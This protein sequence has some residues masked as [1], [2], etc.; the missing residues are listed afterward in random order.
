MF[1]QFVGLA[2]KGVTWRETLSL[3]LARSKGFP[4]F[5]GQPFHKTIYYHYHHYILNPLMY[6]VPEWSDTF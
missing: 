1:E 4:P 6:N 2:L 5:V 3:A